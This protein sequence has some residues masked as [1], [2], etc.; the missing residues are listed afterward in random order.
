L[1][2]GEKFEPCKAW[3]GQGCEV[4]TGQLDKRL[5]TKKYKGSQMIDVVFPQNNEKEFARIAEKLGIKNLCFVYSQKDFLSAKQVDTKIKIY[6]GL[7]L[8][9][10]E[11]RKAKG[12]DIII[13]KAGDD[14]RCLLENKSI[15]LLFD[16]ENHSHKDFLHHR[17]SGL[18]QV[19]CAIA[20]KS[21]TIILMDFNT[22][23]KSDRIHCARI[24]GRMMQ[25]VRLCKKYKV[26]LAIASFA[27]EPHE[28]RDL[29]DLAA[30]G[31]IL[32]VSDA[33]GALTAVHRRILLNKKKQSPDYIMEGIERVR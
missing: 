28:M 24:M 6:K 15:D 2:R 8:K 1:A 4:F 16:L 17:N 9:P 10:G 30:F 29:N 32:G 14:N 26:D 5:N 12:A 3:P 11:A 33:K 25:N 21:R 18:N 20:N 31:R 13:V 7:I 27:A 19:F 23:L 22:V